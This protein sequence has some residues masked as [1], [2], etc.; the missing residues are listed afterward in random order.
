MT[1]KYRKSGRRSE[2]RLAWKREKASW[3]GHRPDILS[4]FRIVRYYRMRDH[5]AA[6]DDALNIAISWESWCLAGSIIRT[7]DISSYREREPALM[8]PVSW[9]H[10]PGVPLAPNWNWHPIN[11]LP[12]DFASYAGRS[13]A[14]HFCSSVFF[15][16][17]RDLLRD[18]G[19]NDKR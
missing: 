18:R 16:F 17:V 14:S 4:R 7:T 2:E 10:F 19:S 12:A 11:S 3:I 13:L 15:R 5:A 9:Y 8:K 6:F 1:K